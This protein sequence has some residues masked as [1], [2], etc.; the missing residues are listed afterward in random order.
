VVR[1]RV[2]AKI[3]VDS[4]EYRRKPGFLGGVDKSETGFFPAYWLI[5]F[6]LGKNPVSRLPIIISPEISLKNK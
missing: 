6:N 4:L 3:L 2:F 5:A 1:S